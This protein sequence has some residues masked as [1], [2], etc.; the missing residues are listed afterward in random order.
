MGS[1]K[2][3]VIRALAVWRK[4]LLCWPLWCNPLWH[5]LQVASRSRRELHSALWAWTEPRVTDERTGQLTACPQPRETLSGAPATL[6]PDSCS[7]KPVYCFW[8]AQVVIICYKAVETLPDGGLYSGKVK[9]EGLWTGDV[10]MDEG[11]G[12]DWKGADACQATRLCVSLSSLWE[13]NSPE[14]RH[15][16]LPN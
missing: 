14:E 5:K 7:S 11:R 8:A 1:T 15:W 2:G 13:L 10:N 9:A 4:R 6:C 12:A 3:Y 16:R